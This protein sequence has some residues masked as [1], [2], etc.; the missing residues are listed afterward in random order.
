MHTYITLAE[1]GS[2]GLELDSGIDSGLA[3][4][5]RV[6]GLESDA[7]GLLRFSCLLRKCRLLIKVLLS[8]VVRKWYKMMDTLIEVIP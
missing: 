2:D 8:L 6:D 3:L 1:C 7:D 5:F 4:L